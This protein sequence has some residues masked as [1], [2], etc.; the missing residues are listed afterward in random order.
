M[1][2]F[3][4]LSSWLFVFLNLL[5]YINFEASW[6]SLQDHSER[7]Q[8]TQLISHLP[9]FHGCFACNRILFWKYWTQVRGIF[10]LWPWLIH[11]TVDLRHRVIDRWY[12]IRWCTMDI[13]WWPHG[14]AEV[15]WTF[16]DDP[17]APLRYHDVYMLPWWKWTLVAVVVSWHWYCGESMVRLWILETVMDPWYTL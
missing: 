5:R 1:S 12:H 15:P 7:K 8:F 13:P 17:M 2:K 10:N 11:G 6:W 4:F 16:C 3:W 9:V 14:T